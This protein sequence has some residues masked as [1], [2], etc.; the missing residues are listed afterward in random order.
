M[1]IAA[2]HAGYIQNVK[3]VQNCTVSHFVHFLQGP[4]CHL[5]HGMYP[6]SSSMDGN[7]RKKVG[8]NDSAL[9]HRFIYCLVFKKFNDREKSVFSIKTVRE[10]IYSP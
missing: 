10:S 1:L 9:G 3:P 2:R 5:L 7:M 6:N 4:R 8:Q